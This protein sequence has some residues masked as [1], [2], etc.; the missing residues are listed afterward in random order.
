MNPREGLVVKIASQPFGGYQDLL[1]VVS[2]EDFFE[3]NKDYGSIG[4]NL[5]EHPGP[6]RFYSVLRSIRARPQVQDVLVSISE[7][8]EDDESWP[9]SDRVYIFTSAAPEE[10]RDWARELQP[11]E[12][13]EGFI[14]GAPPAAP[15]LEPGMR[16][17]ALW[18]D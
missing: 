5:D 6:S 14:G 16:V 15:A 2:L 9:Y 7:V 13:E 4:C 1:P 8:P 10:L 18:W 17:L 3:G 11:S 12:V